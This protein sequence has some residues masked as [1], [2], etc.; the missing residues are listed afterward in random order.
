MRLAWLHSIRSLPLW[1]V[2]TP[3]NLLLDGCVMLVILM[4]KV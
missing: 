2:Y 4:L 1:A 3:A